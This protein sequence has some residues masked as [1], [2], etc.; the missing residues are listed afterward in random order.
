MDKGNIAGVVL[1]G[2]RSSR[3]GQDKALLKFKDKPLLNHMIEVLEQ[4]GLTDIYV[5]GE[6]EGYRCIPDRAPHAGPAH[7]ISDMLEQLDGYEGTL[8]VPVDLP[9]LQTEVL[10]LLLKE[11]A[12]G[13]FTGSPLPAFITKAYTQK[14]FKSIKELL[15]ANNIRPIDLP[16]NLA[17]CI[18]NTNT[19]EEWAE[20]LRT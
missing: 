9:L 20:A 19:P 16:P 5:S 2:G 12:G 11:P 15:V 17:S 10:A 7:A 6:F 1:A 14:R 13:Y 4:A 3:M 18:T 8:F